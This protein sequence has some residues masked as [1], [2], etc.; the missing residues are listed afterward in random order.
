[1]KKRLLFFLSV[2][3]TMLLAACGA[4]V[5]RTVTIFKNE[6]WRAEILLEV[7]TSSLAFIGSP[8][9]LETSFDESVQDAVEMGVDASWR[10]KNVEGAILYTFDLEGQGLDTLKDTVFESSTELSAVETGGERQIIFSDRVSSDLL[11]AGN[12][13]LTLKGGEIVSSNGQVLDRGTVQWVNPSGRLEAVLTEKGGFNIAGLLIVFVFGGA[14]AGAFFYWRSQQQS[15]KH[16]RNC[17]TR[18][19]HQ[20]KFCPKCGQQQ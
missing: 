13:T 2:I 10:S 5:E 1:M 9:Q 6:K 11:S 18:L 20:A 16:C 12:N 15:V 17:G 7:P 19:N 3:S 8:E 4:N 14:I